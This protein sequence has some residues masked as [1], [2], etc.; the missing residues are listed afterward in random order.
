[1]ADTL[2]ST[3]NVEATGNEAQILTDTLGSGEGYV[4]ISVS[5]CNIHATRDITFRLF[6]HNTPTNTTCFFYHN[7]PLP[8]SSTFIF[9]TKIVLKQGDQ[10]QIEPTDT[11]ANTSATI[12]VNVTGMKQTSIT[13]AAGDAYF[14]RTVRS[15]VSYAP[16]AITPVNTNDIVTVLSCI[17]TNYDREDATIFSV[18]G[19]ITS[20]ED[21]YY[22]YKDH[23]L[24]PTSTFE[25][26]DELV[27]EPND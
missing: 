7:Q 5:I 2:F 8:A 25:H 1:M 20:S 21:I 22:L 17:F 16:V 10:L 27:L 13:T 15:A 18:Y 19:K 11:P 12:H 9:N 6:V 4:I 24:P 14:D 3:W 23:P 26:T